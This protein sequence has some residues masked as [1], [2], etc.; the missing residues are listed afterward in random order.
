MALTYLKVVAYINIFEHQIHEILMCIYNKTHSHDTDKSI[1][2]DLH[3]TAL[4]FRLL[5]QH[6]FNISQEIFSDF[7]DEVGNLKR[8]LYDD[9]KGILSLYEASFL[10]EEG[11][12]VLDSARE[13]GYN[14]LRKHVQQNQETDPYYA[15]L[16]NHALE[17]PLHWRMQRLESRWFID[18][19]EV[20]HGMDSH[21]LELAKLDFNN[22]QATYQ[23]DLQYT[24]CWWKSTC[25]AEK[26]SFIRDRLVENFLWAVG[27]I[28]EPRFGYCRRMCSKVYSLIT[29]I[30]DIYDVYGTLEELELFTDAV[31]RWEVTEI[32]HL[33]DYMKI[34]F[35]CL[36]N[37]IN[38]IGYD[39]LKEKGFH[40]IPYLKKAWVDLCE[41]YLLEAK[42]YHSRYTPT[43]EE[44]TENA[45]ISISG[46]VILVHVFFLTQ[47]KITFDSLK[48]LKEYPEIVRLSSLVLRLAN[49]LGTSSD[50]LKRGDIPKLIQ[51]YMNESGASEDEARQYIQCLI[52]ETWKKMTKQGCIESPL[53]SKAFIG[54]AMDLARMAQCAYQHGD[55]YGIPDG[56]TKD[57]VLSILVQPIPI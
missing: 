37:T 51:C 48:Y 53:L 56:E 50:E 31:Q 11:E 30:D 16:I 5:R 52:S 23:A 57:H 10:S 1:K 12:N 24:S 20:K 39:V 34:C 9:Y 6:G 45:W 41:A 36:H 21:I 54:I 22:V 44:Y 7:Q 47:D 38:E 2:K 42:W 27:Q 3:F 40:I 35:V 33:P 32:E 55:G 29:T 14:K 46:P 13:F 8:N 19:Y 28:Y 49:D 15:K 18:M 26:L 17:L 4:E 43:V 25:L